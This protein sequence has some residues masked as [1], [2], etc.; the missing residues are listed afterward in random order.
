M[1]IT[2]STST[3]FPRTVTPATS[4]RD[5]QPTTEEQSALVELRA[6]ERAQQQRAVQEKLQ[7][8]K[9]ETQ[10][11]LDG[12]LISF[13]HQ[14]DDISSEQK[15]SSYNQSRVNEA[16]NTAREEF[17]RSENEQSQRSQQRE[18]EPIDIVV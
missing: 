1:E 14:Q 9:D 11:R 6:N 13:G 4:S 12:R 15:Q 18:P 16:Y 5:R 8:N 7:Q 10:R 2:S 3:S 17:L